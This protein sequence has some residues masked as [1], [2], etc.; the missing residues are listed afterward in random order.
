MAPLLTTVTS[1]SSQ[2]HHQSL[3]LII[4]P[5]GIKTNTCKTNEW[6]S[7]LATKII[8]M[9]MSWVLLI[10]HFIMHKATW[11][12]FSFEVNIASPIPSSLPVSFPALHYECNFNAI[13]R[14]CEIGDCL[15][16]SVEGKGSLGIGLR[17]TC[18]EM[19]FARIAKD[20]VVQLRSVFLEQKYVNN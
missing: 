13:I 20:L 15:G 3:Q 2:A 6:I 9:S 11:N 12:V 8:P 19:L 17:W 5:V 7:D 14:K 18:S 1:L 16:G 4:S 10:N